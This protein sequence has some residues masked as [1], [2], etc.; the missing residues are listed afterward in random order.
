[1]ACAS[2]QPSSVPRRCGSSNTIGGLATA[3]ADVL[4]GQGISARLH[5]IGIP[6]EYAP[7]GPPTHLYRH[8]G[9][10]AAGFLARIREVTASP[11]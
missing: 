5:R 6:G 4:A 8:Y 11:G 9:L 3:V 10:D 2:G 1:M 7:V